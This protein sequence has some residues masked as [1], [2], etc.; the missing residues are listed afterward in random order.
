MGA[1]NNSII[2]T[3]IDYLLLFIITITLLLPVFTKDGSF[4]IYPDNRHQAY[5]Y[6]Q[7]LTIALHKGYLPVW[8]AN[9]YGGRS[10]TGEFQSAIFYPPN[11]IWSLLFGNE[12]GIDVYYIDLLVALHYFICLLG[13]YHL[14][15]V[16]N[17]NRVAA[18]A[19]ALIFTFTGVLNLRSGGQTCIHAGL[20]LIPWAVYFIARY[21]FSE[22]KKKYL[23]LA[24]L[25]CGLQIL[26]GH[27]QPLFHTLVIIGFFIIY[28]EYQR[29]ENW[30]SFI[31]A[32]IGKPL[33]I[34]LPALIL[35]LP[36]LYY[37]M[38]Y[39][40]K[41]YRWVSADHPIGPG[42]KVPI[43]VYAH[44]FILQA[45]SIF[46]LFGQEFNKTEDGDGL[47]MGI[48]PLFLFTAYIIKIKS[49]KLSAQ[50]AI[51]KNIL[52]T[53]LIFSLLSAL[54][55][56]T[57][58]HWL[59]YHIPF[60]DAVRELER[61]L[62]L[63]NFSAALIAGLAIHHLTELKTNIFKEHPKT[64]LFILGL[65]VING[66]YLILW[67]KQYVQLRVSIPFLLG[68]L[69]LLLLWYV[70]KLNVLYTALIAFICIDLYFNHVN[71]ADTNTN[72]YP[73]KYFARNSIINF[74]E[75][76]YGKY[77]VLDDIE[78]DDQTRKNMG[79]VYN[80]QTKL[81]HS[82]TIN[83]SYFDFMGEG[84]ELTSE[85]HDLMNI[86]YIVTDKTLDSNFIFRD[87]TDKIKLY[88][89]KTYYPRIYWQ[90]QLGMQGK[91]IEEQNKTT[92]KQLAYS[93]IYHKIEVNCERPDTL[94]V[95]ENNYPGWRCYDNNKKIKVFSAVIKNYT[96]LF[97][98]VVLDK[99]HHILEFKY[100]K[101]FYWF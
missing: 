49:I 25:I 11:I 66:I 92:I 65:L 88:E 27:I 34:I 101:V 79:D 87:S 14:A 7:K 72:L 58:F 61:Y 77:R 81:G 18:I 38:E 68:F 15:K 55:Y 8:D 6:F 3:L 100:N 41:C 86:R 9:T 83:K 71:F 48:L 64:K 50:H 5:P 53:I 78:Q 89:R 52:F 29:K 97:R 33:L 45:S 90:H 80:I 47:Y 20:A 46:N 22:S 23:F 2:N 13:M 1:K 96:P 17:L 10:F 39:M 28:F 19:S 85:A 91:D 24:G 12:H 36:Q 57:F 76:G 40:S 74:L 54:G 67:Q 99:G 4:C 70:K 42:E 35:A 69:F 32:I 37:A 56:L 26:S 31:K 30:K 59:I 62:V 43:S 73:P 60:V 21:Y 98:A 93:D 84:W 82:A 95:S 16:L 75:E 63:F 44:K 94:I 51:L